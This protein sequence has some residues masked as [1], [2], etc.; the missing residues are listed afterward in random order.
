MGNINSTENDSK[1]ETKVENS[2]HKDEYI[3][4]YKDSA[5]YGGIKIKE[6]S[7]PHLGHTPPP[8][9]ELST[10]ANNERSKEHLK[11]L[12]KIT[13]KLNEGAAQKKLPTKQ[14]FNRFKSKNPPCR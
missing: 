6:I 9:D 13:E 3:P 10:F 12:S 7:P 1:P 5:V 4:T 14:M 2:L 8:C 11:N